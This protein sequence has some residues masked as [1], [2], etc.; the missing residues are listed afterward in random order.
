MGQIPDFQE[1][2]AAEKVVEMAALPAVRMP[3]A[4]R[5]VEFRG[6]RRRAVAGEVPPDQ[7]LQIARP[8]VFRPERPAQD[9]A[10]EAL[11]GSKFDAASDTRV[12]ELHSLGPSGRSRTGCLAGGPGMGWF[13]C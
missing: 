10:V 7:A 5:P 8:A 13:R 1:A 4:E 11:L 2:H 9:L 12:G 3:R 6:G